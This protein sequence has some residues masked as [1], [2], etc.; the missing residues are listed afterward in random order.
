MEEAFVYIIKSSLVLALFV[1]AFMLLVRGEA[2]HS[3]KRGLLLFSALFSVLLP[4]LFFGV[5]IDEPAA[6]LSTQIDYYVKDGRVWEGANY[7]VQYFAEPTL[8]QKI[9]DLTLADWITYIY[10]A[11]ASIMLLRML[12]VYATAIMTMRE[13][14]QQSIARYRMRGVRLYV[15]DDEERLPFSWFGWI[16]VSRADIKD[17][18][19]EILCHEKMHI[20]CRHSFDVLLADILV[21]LQWFNPLAWKLKTLL[22][23]LH[24]YEADAKV[25]AS[26]INV[27]KYKRAII[28]EAVGKETYAVVCGFNNYIIKKR[29]FMMT[30]ENKSVWQYAKALYILPLAF[31]TA[32]SFSS[33]DGSGS[34]AND[35][36][37]AA[38][39]TYP[40]FI[41][42]VDAL[43]DYLVKNVNYPEDARL[44][45]QEGRVLVDFVVE[46][47]GSITDVTVARSSGFEALDA[48]AKRVVSSMSKW[49]PGVYKGVAVR[50]KFTQPVVFRLDVPTAD[51][52]DVQPEF[53]GGMDALVS[54]MSK[55]VKYPEDCKEG[56]IEGRV[57]V[58][59]IVAAD[60][61]VCNV[62]VA[63]SSNNSSLDAEA[64]RVV[65][66]MPNW[67]PGKKDGKEVDVRF[68]LPVVFKL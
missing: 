49:T 45:R 67:K 61:K 2:Y 40:Q 53:P 37:Y 16:F 66:S 35:S 12:P 55:G 31:L 9:A 8:W 48:E 59:F 32:C 21:A 5:T 17:G 65:T 33:N 19:R 4:S 43:Q 39:D 44:K 18:G 68:C 58:E 10:F 27:G 51:A 34:A 23:E 3:T 25:V 62:L 7:D 38:V 28:R 15:H 36:I 63:E 54:Y 26:G 1:A 22:Q 57:I 46:V 50:T 13:L 14:K 56:G 30:K 11:V 60:G 29:I 64:V 41:G 52:I 20:R 47:D 42:G 24:E 6:Y